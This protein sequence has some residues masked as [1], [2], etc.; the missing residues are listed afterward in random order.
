MALNLRFW[1]RI[2]KCAVV[3]AAAVTVG[4]A[5]IACAQKAA[6]DVVILN[7]H[8]YTVNAKQP[9]A[10]AIAIRGEEIIAVGS[11]KDVAHYRNAKTKVIDA[12]GRLV[13]PG[14]TDCHTHFLDGGLSLERIH[15]D[16]AKDVAEKQ[17]RVKA[18]AEAHPDQLWVRGRGWT[19]PAVG[20]TNLPDKKDLDA[21]IP[22]R[23]VYLEA[24]DGHTW[25]ANSKA[26]NWLESPATH[27]ILPAARSYAMPMASLPAL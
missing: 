4:Q 18:Y 16:D 25:W 7:A 17:R 20:P 13:L 10:E 3:F 21:I 27:R 5:P 8:A 22:D 26:L 6:A 15:L 2:R 23:P 9:W 14:F 24:F 1:L 11:A 12:G 19:Y